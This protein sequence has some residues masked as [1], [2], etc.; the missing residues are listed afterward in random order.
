MKNYKPKLSLR[1][2]LLTLVVLF[3]VVACEKN[4]TLLQ[5]QEI[6]LAKCQKA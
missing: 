6:K 5:E 1:S 4:E 2:W 3:A